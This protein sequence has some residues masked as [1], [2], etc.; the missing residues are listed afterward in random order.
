MT[1][2]SPPIEDIKFLLNEVVGLDEI[3][4]FPGYEDVSSDLVS[5]ILIEAGKFASEILAP[6]NKV[7]DIEGAR[8][9]NDVVVTPAGW[10]GAYRRFVEAGWGSLLLEKS[11]G[12]QGLPR[13]VGAAVQE[14]WDGANMAFGLC[15]MIRSEERR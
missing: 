4:S 2:Y 6:L 11:Y 5:S 12:G 15:P 3:C 8:L 10:K 13:L 14:M 7:G 9:E 1:D